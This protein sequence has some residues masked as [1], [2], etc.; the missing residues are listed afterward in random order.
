[1][2]RPQFQDLKQFSGK[3]CRE[4]VTSFPIKEFL[5]AGQHPNASEAAKSSIAGLGPERT[6]CKSPFRSPTCCPLND[7]P[8]ASPTRA[9]RYVPKFRSTG[10]AKEIPTSL[11]ASDRLP[12]IG[13][14]S[15]RAWDPSFHPI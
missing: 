9:S 1:V 6:S 12:R 7:F 14:D 2:E 4:I 3:K 13:T 10:N 5:V 11:L 8:K 15:I